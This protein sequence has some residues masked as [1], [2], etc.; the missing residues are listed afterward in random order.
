MARKPQSEKVFNDRPRKVFRKRIP[1]AEITF[2]VVF[3]GVV[4]AMGAWFMGKEDDFDPSE[5]DISIDVMQASVVEDNLYRKPFKP[6][7]DPATAASASGPVVQTGAFPASILDGGWTL[8]S[9][10]Q[11]FTPESLY[12]KVNGAADQ[13][14]NFGME[15]AYFISIAKEAEDLDIGIEV[16]DQGTFPNALGVFAAQR[17]LDQEVMEKGGAYYFPTEIG[18][19]GIANS[20][21]F[22]IAANQSGPAIQ[23]K[24]EQLIDSFTEM[25]SEAAE[26]PQTFM[27]LSEGLDLPFDSIVYEKQDVFQFGFAKEFWFGQLT[28][29]GMARYFLHESENPDGANELFS[30]LVENQLFDYELVEQTGTQAVLKHQ[31]LEDNYFTVVKK[32]SWVY[33]IDGAADVQTLKARTTQL[34]EAL[35]Q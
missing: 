26:M 19:I 8:S 14:I 32:G 11:D 2:S 34:E 24:A 35:S 10:Y 18:A 28:P 27:I 4:I 1:V 5:R 17:D 21:Y 25:A 33:G 22:K 20:L 23:E 7:V 29:D 30:K 12:E 31:F 9:R 13:Y 3:V 16:Y 6:W 15:K